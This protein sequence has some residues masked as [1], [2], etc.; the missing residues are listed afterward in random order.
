M[1]L[2]ISLEAIYPAD[3]KN[4]PDPDPEKMA[5]LDQSVLEGDFS[6]LI[7]VIEGCDDSA[8]RFKIEP[9][10]ESSFVNLET[11]A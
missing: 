4:Y 11:D 6:T 9:C 5:E 10:A 3:T 8:I 1:Y 7:A 2:K